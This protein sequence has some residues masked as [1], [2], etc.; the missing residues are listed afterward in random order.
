MNINDLKKALTAEDVIRRYNLDNLSSDRKKIKQA[1]ETL[2]KTDKELKN[3]IDATTKDME[4][5]QNQV[6]GNI[7]TWFLSGVPTIENQ[8]ANEWLTDKDK[9]NHLGDLYYDQDTGYAY[10]F[11]LENDEYKWL[12]IVDSDV[13][14]ALAIANSAKDTADSKR[15]IFVV[16]PTTPYEV[17]DVWIKEDKV[18]YRCRAKRTE[19]DFQSVDWILATDY[20]NDDY[21]KNVE[22]ILNAFKTTVESDYV[23]NVKLETTASGIQ[24]SVESTTTKLESKINNNTTLIN[25]SNLDI[26]KKLENLATVENITELKQ[27]VETLQTST[28]LSINIINETI[29]NGV[30]K[31]KTEKGFTFDDNGLTI[32]SNDS[33]SKFNADTD[34]I[35]V[36]D[37]SND[38]ELLFAGYDENLK[39]SVLRVDNIEMDKYFSISNEYRQEVINDENHGRGLAFFNIGGD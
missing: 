18:L 28:E 34:A 4:N 7:T 1:T 30:P 35:V 11:A 38:N 5:I 33:K 10:R 37:K 27:A 32:D 24:S 3:F 36:I 19:G 17:G 8:P 6:D 14:E 13:T 2:V 21:A 39:R 16:E 26:Q 15:Q 31:L 29:E 20:T 9:N 12:K 23:T 25:N 22:A